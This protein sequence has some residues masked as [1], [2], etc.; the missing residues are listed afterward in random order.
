MNKFIHEYWSKKQS[1]KRMIESNNVSDS[2]LLFLV[3]NNVKKIH[4]LPLTR[5]P[6]RQ[7]K[8]RKAKKKE[9]IMAFC[10]WD[11]IEEVINET[12]CCNISNDEWFEKFVDFKDLPMGE[13]HFTTCNFRGK[14][15]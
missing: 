7:K 15:I 3:P 8:K 9:F 4:G 14:S 13:D 5:I 12:I 2:D 11:V 10:L 6:G 1:G